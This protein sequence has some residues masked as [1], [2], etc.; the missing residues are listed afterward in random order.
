[1]YSYISP[2]HLNVYYCP[3]SQLL[4]YFKL[5]LGSQS[6]HFM[7][8]QKV[9]GREKGE[10]MGHRKTVKSD[11]NLW[12]IGK[13]KFPLISLSRDITLSTTCPL[14]SADNGS[15]STISSGPQNQ[16][17]FEVSNI[18]F[19]LIATTQPLSALL[20]CCIISTEFPKIVSIGIFCWVSTAHDGS[21]VGDFHFCFCDSL[22]LYSNIVS[23]DWAVLTLPKDN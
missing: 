20:H 5:K 22:P 18:F 4:W 16:Q 13:I 2:G 11:G 12:H 7:W 1:M 14:F 19:S 6:L 10:E 15:S 17:P 9:Y 21:H 23:N 8:H 3:F